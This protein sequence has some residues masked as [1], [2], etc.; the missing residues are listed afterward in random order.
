MTIALA[1]KVHDGVVLAADS[2]TTITARN[3]RGEEKVQNVYNNANKLFNLVKGLPIGGM[4][5]GSG[6]VGPASIATLIKDL[7]KRFITKPAEGESNWHLDPD[8]YKIGDVA[9]A[10]KRFFEEQIAA[11]PDPSPTGGFLVTGYSAGGKLAESWHL[12]IENG[13]VS[14]P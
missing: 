9:G 4:T 12:E 11:F 14:E 7:R 2:A 6:S 1:I 13:V 8:G 5:W 10:V 3:Q